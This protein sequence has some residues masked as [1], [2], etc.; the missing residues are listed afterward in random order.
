MAPSRDR[1]I[2][3]VHWALLCVCFSCPPDAIIISFQLHSSQKLKIYV[4]KP[5]AFNNLPQALDAILQ[6]KSWGKVV[7]H[8]QRLAEA[9]QSKL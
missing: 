4:Y 1:L 2:D 8:P 9:P 7:L 5:F 3:I 6:R